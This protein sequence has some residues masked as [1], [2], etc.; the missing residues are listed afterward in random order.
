MSQESSKEA[1]TG[2]SIA[3]SAKSDEQKDMEVEAKSPSPA[4]DSPED[5]I[6]P[7]PK[8]IE[9][10]ER[11]VE[12]WV[13]IVTGIHEEA[14]DEDLYEFF[15]EYGK[16]RGLHMNL[17]RQTGYIKGYALLEFEDYDEAKDA[18]VNGSGKKI[19]GKA[20]DVDFAFIQGENP[21]RSH[22]GRRDRRRD[23]H[24]LRLRSPSVDRHRSGTDS[25]VPDHSYQS[26]E[27]SRELS[28]ERGF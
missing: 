7:L 6:E 1:S 12:G 5:S 18:V 14:R 19:L 17:D 3:G 23:R 4:R 21:G 24:Q 8:S 27:R 28:P 11:S 10:A 2:M 16:A 9:N 13:I 15:A 22:H 25:Y 20:V 26:S